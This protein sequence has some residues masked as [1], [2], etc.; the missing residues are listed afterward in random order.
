MPLNCRLKDN[1]TVL[2]MHNLQMSIELSDQSGEYDAGAIVEVAPVIFLNNLT[3]NVKGSY[4]KISLNYIPFWNDRPVGNFLALEATL[5]SSVLYRTLRVELL[6]NMI[7]QRI[8]KFFLPRITPKILGFVSPK[9]NWHYNGSKLDFPKITNKH[10][11][12]HSPNKCH[13]R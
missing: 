3:D 2:I 4:H 13:N 6:A 10:Y 11:I 5:P 8:T 9:K 7:L 1:A 12:Q